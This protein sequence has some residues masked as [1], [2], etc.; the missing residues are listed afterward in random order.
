MLS[1]LL[2]HEFRATGRRMLPTLGVLAL[3]GLLANLSIRL[4]EKDLGGTLFKILLG[5][6]I[7]AFFIGITV[8]WIM[9]LVLMI[10]RFY[11]NLLKDEG[12]L[13]FTLPTNTHAL[14]WSKLIVSTVWFFASALLIILLMMLTGANVAKLSI[15]DLQA[16]SMGFGEVLEVL[17]ELGVTNGSLWLLAGELVLASVLTCL[18]ACLHFYAAMGL[19]Q[20]SATKKGLCSVLAFIGINIAFQIIGGTLFSG[21]S[22]SGSLDIVIDSFEALAES[23][24]GIIRVMNTGIGGAMLLELLQGVVLYVITTLTLNRKLNLA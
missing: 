20:M 4:L 16:A 1:M 18:T 10:S 6:F 19:G 14:V 13:M 15:D 8:V 22:Q 9:T 2:K 5:L 12:Y 17:H 3:L 7:A 23:A 11:R 21:L 24:P